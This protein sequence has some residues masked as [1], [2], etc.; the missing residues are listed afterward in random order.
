MTCTYLAISK[1]SRNVQGK[2]R[3][4][5]CKLFF[6]KPP[7]YDSITN[8]VLS[9]ARGTSTNLTHHRFFDWPN[10]LLNHFH[11]GLYSF[12]MDCYY[13]L[14]NEPDS[15]LKCKIGDVWGDDTLCSR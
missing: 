9:K 3:N 13:R 14:R 7:V 4:S 11:V 10:K 15:I 12:S 1:S 8:E 5:S 6:E 2:R